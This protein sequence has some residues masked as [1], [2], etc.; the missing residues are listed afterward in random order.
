VA[1][2]TEFRRASAPRRL[3][4]IWTWTL[5]VVAARKLREQKACCG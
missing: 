1:A 2:S 4:E 5:G 3:P